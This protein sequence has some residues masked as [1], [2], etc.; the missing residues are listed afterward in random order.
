MTWPFYDVRIWRQ[1]D[2][3]STLMCPLGTVIFTGYVG[4]V[5]NSER[6]FE[7]FVQQFSFGS[8]ISVVSLKK[9][10]HERQDENAS[11]GKTIFLKLN[12]Y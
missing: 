9:K 6:R 4:L 7:L 10:M 5:F 1:Y 8:A 3:I 11:N 2:V 12:R